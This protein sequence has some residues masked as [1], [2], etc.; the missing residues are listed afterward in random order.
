MPNDQT[1]KATRREWRELGFFYDR[2]DEA[3]VWRI[4]GSRSGL[5]QFR[6]ALLKYVGD[7]RNAK[8]SEHEHYGPYLYLKIMTW[9]EAGFDNHAIR[10]QLSDF[11]R[12]ARLVE[13]KVAKTEPGLSARILEEFA[14]GSPYALVLEVREDDFD[15]ASAD[16]VLPK[17]N[18]G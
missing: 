8:K 15:P 12:L 17:E 7:P 5:L 13:D 16:P 10:G 4:V 18:V 2:D 1:D 9:P 6:N 11:A 14:E 3:K